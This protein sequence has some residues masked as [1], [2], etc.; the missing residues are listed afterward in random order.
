[1]AFRQPSE[2]DAVASAVEVVHGLDGEEDEEF[3]GGVFLIGPEAKAVFP[4]V[5]DD[6]LE[7]LVDGVLIFTG[8]AS[9]GLAEVSASAFHIG[10]GRGIFAMLIGVGKESADVPI[11]EPGVVQS[12]EVSLLLV[13]LA[14]SLLE[15]PDGVDVLSADDEWFSLAQFLHEFV[16]ELQF[17]EGGPTFVLLA[18]AGTGSQPNGEGFGEVFD[19][20]CLGVPHVEVEDEFFAEGAG[21][22]IT[23]VRL[24]DATEDF[25]IASRASEAIGIVDGMSGF[26]AEDAH[27]LRFGGAFGLEHHATFESDE[28]GMREIEG[29]GDS[30]DPVGSVP[31]IGE[32]EVR[33]EVEAS[34]FEFRVEFFDAVFEDGP[35]DF[36]T[37]IADPHVQKLII[38]QSI[39]I[40]FAV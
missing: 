33:A 13:V 10:G 40:E 29:D 7:D 23:A 4:A 12:V 28:S 15:L 26:V 3:T 5:A 25:A 17:F 34:G 2:G 19:G 21:F 39:Q 36:D 38:G 14:E 24:R 37:Q 9:D 6:F 22:V 31:A 1:M 16:D 8:P 27:A 30:G 20:V 11:V 32:P 35:F 18:P